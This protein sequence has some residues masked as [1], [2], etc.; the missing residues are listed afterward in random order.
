MPVL[1]FSES[2]LSFSNFLLFFFD[3]PTNIRMSTRQYLNYRLGGKTGKR[4]I[5]TGAVIITPKLATRGHCAL[6]LEGAQWGPRGWGCY[7]AFLC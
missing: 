1:A 2:F 5:E 7:S 4:V 6:L 3:P